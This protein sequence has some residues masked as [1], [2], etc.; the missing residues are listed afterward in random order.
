M[1]FW[2]NHGILF[3]ICIA[4]FPRLTL[5]FAVASPFGLLH[6]LGWIF[7]PHLLV[8]I[9]A[10]YRYW[11]TNPFLCVVAWLIAFAG[12][13]GEGETVRRKRLTRRSP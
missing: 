11:D 1:D 13:V 8:A 2:D 7:T 10:T 12:T 6:W 9:M 5:L 3:L 4:I